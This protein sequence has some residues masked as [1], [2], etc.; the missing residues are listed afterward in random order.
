MAT[1]QTKPTG[2]QFLM[3]DPRSLVVKAQVRTERNEKADK[4]FF[5]QVK[6][7]GAIY[8]PVQARMING[9]PHLVA[10]HRRTEAAIAAELPLI[11]VYLSD[12][13]DSDV[14]RRQMI[15]NIHREGLS[16]LDTA[17]GVKALHEGPDGGVASKTA[18]LL[19]KSN[20]WVSKMLLVA[21]GDKAN[22]GTA[23]ITQKLMAADKLGDLESAYMLTKLEELNPVAAQE[24]ADN[25]DNETRASIKKRLQNVKPVKATTAGTPEEDDNEP[26]Y[27]WM[28]K[29]IQA[30]SVS[31]KDAPLQEAAVTMIQE[32]L[33]ESEEPASM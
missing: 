11:P 27:R 29:V 33:G 2:P 4:E 16:L 12:V 30:A 21:G 8:Q 1:N 18:A 23:T 25:I 15:E 5:A 3:L 24:V 13:P 20:G 6:A 9:K 31:R 14:L 26:L 10:G 7:D 28:L 17:R 19:G 22:P 32:W